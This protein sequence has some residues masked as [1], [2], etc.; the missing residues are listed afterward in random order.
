MKQLTKFIFIFLGLFLAL[1]VQPHEMNPARLALE[2]GQDGS[3]SGLWMFP[4]N[5]VGLPAE[6]SFTD[7]DEEERNLPE[8]QGKYLVSNIVINCTES[9][10][11]K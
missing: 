4:T 2:E 5:A 8:V 6:V 11:G 7:C 3:Y 10:K 1:L 9:L